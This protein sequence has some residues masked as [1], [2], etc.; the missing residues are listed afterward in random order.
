VHCEGHAATGRSTGLRELDGVAV[1]RRE[2]LARGGQRSGGAEIGRTE[3]RDLRGAAGVLHDV[4][5]ADNVA[6]HRHA[7]AQRRLRK[8]VLLRLRQRSTGRGGEECGGDDE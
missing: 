5:D 3:D 7:G 2:D 8:R 1:G 4:A 6:A